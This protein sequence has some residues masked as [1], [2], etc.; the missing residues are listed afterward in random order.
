MEVDHADRDG[1]RRRC[2]EY[3]LALEEERRK[4][5]V[6]QREL[7]L[8]FDLVTQTIEGMRSQMDAAGSEET[9]SDQGPPP[10]LEEFIPLKPSLSL[11]SSEEE[12]THADAAKS[13][14]KEEAETSERHSSPPPP[15]PEAKKVTPDWLQS[16]QL[17]SQ[18][19]P[20]QPSSPSPTPTKDLPC[21]PVALNARKAGGA[22]QPFEKEKRAELPA[23]STTAAA[24]STVVGDSGDK[25]TDDDTE[26]H[27]ETDKD[28]DKDA[29]DKDKE[30]QSQPHRK[31]RRCWAPELHRRFLQALQQLGGSHVA[32]P[33][34][35]RELMKVDG[36][37][38][39]E[40]KSHLQKYRLHTRRPSSTGQSSAAAGVPAPPAP[41]FVVVGS[42]WVPPP[43]YAAA[44]AAQQH[45]QLAAAGNNAS[46]S[47]NPVYAPVAMLP[48]G[49]QPHSH[50]KQHQQQQQGQRH[51]GSEGRRSGDAGD[52][53]SS[54][55][56]V[57][58]SSQTTSA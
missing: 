49:L 25:P 30:G 58:S 17:W 21:K 18:E 3:L 39:D 41:Q 2:R 47:A 7:P 10:V 27:M 38:N 26:K 53:S 16:V 56:A 32:T 36:L 45:V 1:A 29:K 40:V 20:Q 8:C 54:S 52:G 23:S 22:F 14:K 5:Q 42:I 11:S 57:S 46:G 6:F 55:P 4:I 37:T 48:A 50:R 13:G 12:S 15:P 44:A 24:S 51:S 43:E 34:Q 31:P 35:I 28:N 19:E 33:K 9:V